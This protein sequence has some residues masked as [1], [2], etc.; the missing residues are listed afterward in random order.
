[1]RL[2]TRSFAA[3]GA[4]IALLAALTGC[5]GTTAS[6]DSDTSTD[7]ATTIE[8]TFASGDSNTIVFAT[9]PDHEGAEQDAQ[10]I[11]DWIAEITGK[12]VKFFEATDYTA[13]VQGLAAGQIDV[14]QISAFTYYQSQAA[15]A[16]I[17]PIGAQ[18][19]AE[20]AEPGYFSV[21]LKNPASSATTLADFAD[22]PVCF[23]NPTSTSG[24]AIPV[25]Q[26]LEAGVTVSDENT[27]YG[28]SHDLNAAKIAEGVDCQVG[29]AQDVDADPLIASGALEEIDRFQVPAAPI[30]MQAAL[31]QDVK[32]QLTAA[33]ADSTQASL[34]DAG[35][36]LNEFLTENWFGFGAVDDSYYDTIR[37]VCTLIADQVEACQA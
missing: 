3:L 8:G 10:P 11:A 37:S 24:R 5:A 20:G 27:V 17:E 31:P 22:Q 30:V 6:A 1:M 26:L 15:G 21:A 23:V 35:I 14:A 33:I 2:N 28:E 4:G 19:T 13:V 29:F 16:E 18:I 9:L 12:E 25:S 36:E 34:T 7:N 32:D